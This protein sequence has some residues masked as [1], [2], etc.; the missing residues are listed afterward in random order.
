MLPSLTIM[1]FHFVNCLFDR[2]LDEKFWFHL[3][4]PLRNVLQLQQQCPAGVSN[5]AHPPVPSTYLSRQ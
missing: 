4:C 2:N 1:R 5:P 3:C